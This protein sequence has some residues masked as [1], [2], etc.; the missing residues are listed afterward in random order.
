MLVPRL[1]V[2]VTPDGSKPDEY[3]CMVIVPLS[4]DQVGGAAPRQIKVR[5]VGTGV[6]HR[7]AEGDRDAL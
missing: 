2:K 6:A 4:G 1:N 3:F 5:R 7:F